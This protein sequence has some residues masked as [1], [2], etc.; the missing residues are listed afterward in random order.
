[1]KNARS[2]KEAANTAAPIFHDLMKSGARKYKVSSA[3]GGSPVPTNPVHVTDFAGDGAAN[4][5]GD[6]KADTLQRHDSGLPAIW[7]MDGTHATGAAVLPNP[8]PTWHVAEATDFT[9]KGRADILWQH[10]SGLSA[11]SSHGSSADKIRTSAGAIATCRAELGSH[12]S[13]PD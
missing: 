7:T 13:L 3:P 11:I 6:G 1:M 12:S 2:A 4:F 5:T 9:G 8:G 10:D